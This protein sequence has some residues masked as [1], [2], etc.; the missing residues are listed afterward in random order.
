LSLEELR[1][2]SRGLVDISSGMGDH[3]SMDVSERGSALKQSEVRKVRKTD[4]R[5]AAVGCALTVLLALLI[6]HPYAEIP[7]SDDF[8]YIRIADTLARTGHIVYTGWVTPIVGCQLYLAALFIKVF[9]FSFTAVRA[10]VMFVT[11]CLALLSQRTLVRAGV[12]G[13]NATI[14]TLA[15]LLS[16]LS[17]PLETTFMTDI[18]GLFAEVFCL[19]ACFR[20][21]EANGWRR[22]ICWIAFAGFSNVVLGS[23]RQIAWLGALVMV[24]SALWIL[25]RSRRVL[26]AGVAIWSVCAVLILAIDLWFRRQPYTQVETLLPGR[27]TERVLFRFSGNMTRTFFELV[28]LLLPILVAFLPTLWRRKLPWLIYAACV[29]FIAN[30]VRLLAIHNVKSWLPPYLMGVA[31]F[32]EWTRIRPFLAIAVLLSLLAFLTAVLARRDGDNFFAP[33]AMTNSSK[34][35]LLLTLPFSAAYLVLISPR[36]GFDTVW[37]RYLLPLVFVAI[38][39]LLR[40]YQEEFGPRLPVASLILVVAFGVYAVASLHD[41]MAR[42]RARAAALNEVLATGVPRT[43]VSGG[44]D[45]DGWTELQYSS[46]VNAPHMRVPAGAV[47]E[48]STHYGI[49]PCEF[50]S[51]DMFPHMLPI[52]AIAETPNEQMEKRFAPVPYRTWFQPSGS[53]YVV[54]FP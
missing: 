5:L 13:W 49:T 6:A 45:F 41:D 4:F 51:C 37:D 19:Y 42:V 33:N 8:S 1:W 31:P 53:I 11:V 21:V 16:P 3:S 26:V 7:I 34:K 47:E 2:G 23:S 15:L 20:A 46:H 10:S 35:I 36:A 43:A 32:S 17:M 38:L 9:G 40:F 22:Q 30:F 18:P 24:P 54:P 25:R 12:G 52:Y 48:K 44:W 39:L 27:I 28:L 50:W 14:G 29:L